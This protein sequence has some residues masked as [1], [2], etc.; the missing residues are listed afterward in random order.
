MEIDRARDRLRPDGNSSH[1]VLDACLVSD[2]A[3]L[4]HQVISELGETITLAVTVK[5]RAEGK[6]EK[7]TSK[8][9]CA[10]R[11][12]PQADVHHA[13]QEQ[14]KQMDVGNVGGF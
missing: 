7:A 5:D 11:A 6:A 1:R 8:R 4:L 12:V 14:T 3:V 9:G 2:E 10:A 13:A